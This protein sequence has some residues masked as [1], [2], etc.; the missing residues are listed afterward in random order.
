MK[1]ETI[2]YQHEGQTL[3]S[4][5]LYHEGEPRPTVLVFPA[6]EGRGEFAFNYAEKLFE[7]GF[8]PHLIDVGLRLYV[9]Q[10]FN[11]VNISLHVD[12]NA[13]QHSPSVS[14]R[15]LNFYIKSVFSSNQ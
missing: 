4:E 12:H 10:Q 5:F 9:G 15:F 13:H 2:Q 1:T 7:K 6:F 8:S 11:F 3:I 14:Y